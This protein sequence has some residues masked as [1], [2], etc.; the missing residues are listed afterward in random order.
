MDIFAVRTVVLAD[1]FAQFTMVLLRMETKDAYDRFFSFFSNI[2][3]VVSIM[4]WTSVWISSF[5]EYPTHLKAVTA[6]FTVLSAVLELL[7][8][9]VYWALV[10]PKGDSS[11]GWDYWNQVLIHALAAPFIYFG[12]F[13]DYEMMPDLSGIPYIVVIGTIYGI[14]YYINQMY[15]LGY[16]T[17]G[18][19]DFENGVGQ[20]IGIIAGLMAGSMLLYPLYT[21][22]KVDLLYGED[23]TWGFF[24]L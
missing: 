6:N 17:Y 8:D 9:V 2:T 3:D 18:F 7:K 13:Y 15:V 23:L 20:A 12:F 5:V 24:E 21:W 11:D 19:L 16:P 1:Q 10:K 14:M 4:T 22:I